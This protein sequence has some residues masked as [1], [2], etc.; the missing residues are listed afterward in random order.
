MYPQQKFSNTIH[1]SFSTVAASIQLRLLADNRNALTVQ[2]IHIKGSK[3]KNKTLLPVTTVNVATQNERG[4][5]I[6]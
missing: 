5:S 6:K 4:A 1:R 2:L 3:C